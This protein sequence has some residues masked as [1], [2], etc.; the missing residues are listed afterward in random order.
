[1]EY[2][3]KELMS[4]WNLSRSGVMKRIKRDDLPVKKREVI[5]TRKQVMDFITLD[6]I[7][8]SNDSRI[9]GTL[10]TLELCNEEHSN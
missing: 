7:E 9:K 3:I 6:E 4:K 10:L 5:I 2:T 1:M 8:I